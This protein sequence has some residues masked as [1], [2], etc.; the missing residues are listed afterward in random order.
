MKKQNKI[1]LLDFLKVCLYRT[2]R[3]RTANL[4]PL[5]KA[6]RLPKYHVQ[7]A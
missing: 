6:F 1:H 4:Y 2:Y 3:R 5:F 7:D